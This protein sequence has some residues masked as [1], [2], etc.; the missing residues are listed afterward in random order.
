MQE[1]VLTA[2][3]AT[4]AARPLYL[5]VEKILTG[6]EELPPD[7][8]VHGT[9]GYDFAALADAL[10]VDPRGEAPL[11][12][13][14]RELVGDVRPLADEVS[15]AKRLVMRNLLS[16]ELHVLASE[17]SRIAESDPHTRD[18][19]LDALR[20][21]LVEV[22]TSF[23]AY[24]TYITPRGVSR[25]DR[26]LLL[27]AVSEARRRSGA[28]DLSVFD[29]VRDVLLTDIGVGKPDAYRGR[30]LRLAMKFQQYTGP[31][32]AKGVEDTALYRYHRLVSLNEVGADPGRL[33]LSIPAFHRANG[34][35]GRSWPHAVLAGSTH[36]SKRSEDVRARLHA[37]SELPGE[38]RRHVARWARLNRRFRS[39]TD[40]LTVP[41]ANAEYLLYQTLVG[42]WPLGEMDEESL[43]DLR[44]RIARY[45]D[46]AVKEAKVHTAWT[47]ANLEYGSALAARTR[48]YQGDRRLGIEPTLESE[49]GYVAQT[50]RLT[51]DRERPVI[52]EKLVALYTSRDSAIS[53]CGLE[54]RKAI[55]RGP[56]F[57]ELLASHAV[58]WRQLWRRF[59]LG[60]DLRDGDGGRTA[61]ILR[62]HLFHLLVT[63]FPNVMD[64]DAGVPARGLH[65]EAYRGHIFWDELFIFPLLDLR[66]PEIT[67]SLLMYRYRRLEEA[68]AAARAEGLLHPGAVPGPDHRARHHP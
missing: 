13:C 30:V 48:A 53:E 39:D 14:Y 55:G 45:M 8:Q 4:S 51:L 42:V 23:P 27:Q 25:R 62:L 58:I 10:F 20:D 41:D 61:A 49:P 60:L 67:R 18:F 21:A 46:K 1:R 38:W 68:R 16:S 66:L 57:G 40:G 47:H 56:R 6:D 32:A 24:R 17:L 26:N 12:L 36:D 19:T 11:D 31:V 37:L 50:F 52:L 2:P 34:R 65:G 5:V 33:G 59:D 54:A 44:G 15:V 43:G 64:L 63:A 28:A 9:T 22:V 29:F 3:E 35:R 7:W